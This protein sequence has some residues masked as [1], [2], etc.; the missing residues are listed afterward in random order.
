MRVA[1]DRAHRCG[2]PVAEDVKAAVRRLTGRA[3]DIAAPWEQLGRIQRI[4]GRPNLKEYRVQ[5]IAA[6]LSSSV[7]ASALT[8][9][10]GHALL[11]GK[12][13]IMYG[14][15]PDTAHIVLCG[16]SGV[17]AGTIS[18]VSTSTMDRMRFFSMKNLLLSGSCFHNH[19][20]PCL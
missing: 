12:I 9:V 3:A 8:L 18:M 7:S 10:G 17:S 20:I 5:P 4:G 19:C 11:G 2:Y 14:R 15:D 1:A 6:I 13:N 16:L